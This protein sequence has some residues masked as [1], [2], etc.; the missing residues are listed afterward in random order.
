MKKLFYSEIL[1][2]YFDSEE[3]CVRAELVEKNN[4]D[5]IAQQKKE[6]EQTKLESRKQAAKIVEAAEA[7]LS[8]ARE[9]LKDAEVEAREA[10]EK[11]VSPAKKKLQ[12]AEHKRYEAI[13]EFNKKFGVYT[14]RYTGQ[15]AKDELFNRLSEIED[16]WNMFRFF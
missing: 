4:R 14:K 5:T 16:L 3:E 11:I 9:G 2:K 6:A 10:Y 7:A 1:N 12:E 15:E 8:E 13:S